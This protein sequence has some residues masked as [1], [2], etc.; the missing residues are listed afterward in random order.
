MKHTPYT[1]IV[2]AISYQLIHRTMPTMAPK[3]SCAIKYSNFANILSPITTSKIINGVFVDSRIIH[4]WK[5][6]T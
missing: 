1:I 2:Y 4:L 6:L 3:Y 5:V